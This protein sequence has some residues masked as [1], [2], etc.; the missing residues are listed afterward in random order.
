MNA[1]TYYEV[2]HRVTWE[3]FE[4]VGKFATL[5]AAKSYIQKSGKGDMSIIEHNLIVNT[6]SS[7]VDNQKSL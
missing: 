1:F 4:S 3:R 2:K 7:V 6:D 5:T